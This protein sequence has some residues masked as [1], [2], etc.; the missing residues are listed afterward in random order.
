LT[1][2]TICRL[3]SDG[4]TYV[5]GEDFK[6]IVPY[7]DKYVPHVDIRCLFLERIEKKYRFIRAA[8]AT[9]SENLQSIYQYGLLPLAPK[10]RLEALRKLYPEVTDCDFNRAV[11]KIEIETRRGYIYFEADEHALIEESTHYLLY[12][13]E[14][15]FCIIRNLPD[16]ERLAKRLR[17]RSKPSLLICDIPFERISYETLLE[18]AG[19]AVA[20]VIEDILCSGLFWP[21]DGR[22]AGLCISQRLPPKHIVGHYH[23]IVKHDQFDTAFKR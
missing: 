8:H 5:N 7:L 1:P 3:I 6:W 11:N 10:A 12:G 15:D 23:P 21:N 2:T 22:G 20:K 14:Y 17:L 18:F 13:S 9:N 19:E 4:P 16:G